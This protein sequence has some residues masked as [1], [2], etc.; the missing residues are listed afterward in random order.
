MQRQ[1]WRGSDTALFVRLGRFRAH[2][3]HSKTT[4]CAELF[5]GVVPLI[6]GN[7]VSLPCCTALGGW[8]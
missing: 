8:T 5:V 6:P 2:Y 1:V 7:S 3:T 4:P